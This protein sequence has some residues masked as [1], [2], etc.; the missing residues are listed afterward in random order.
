MYFESNWKIALQILFFHKGMWENAKVNEI[1]LKK[2]QPYFKGN[3]I[4]TGWQM[5]FHKNICNLSRTYVPT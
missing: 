1:F 3:Q 2:A 5:Y 4:L